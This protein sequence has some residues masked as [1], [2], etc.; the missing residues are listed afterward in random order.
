MFYDIFCSLCHAQKLKPGQVANKIGF[1]RSTITMWKNTGG[2]PRQD[3]LI[4]I[5]RFF[6]V[7]TDYL[8]GK[9]NGTPAE[10]SKGATGDGVKLTPSELNM[11]QK[12]RC[13]D[14]RG[15]SAVLN[16]LEHEYAA[17]PQAVHAEDPA[18][19]A[20]ARS[21]LRVAAR[22]GTFTEYVLTDAQVAKLATYL[23]SLPDVPEDL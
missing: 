11:F 2:T 19:A 7:S 3:L 5:A 1:N 12:F 13:L 16:L 23:D 6:D 9:E 15:R 17:L 4:R 10:D 20:P 14:D 18:P 8:L 22:D 21:I